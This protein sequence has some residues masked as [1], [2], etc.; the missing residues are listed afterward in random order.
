[1]NGRKIDPREL[2]AGINL[3]GYFR[4]ELGVGEAGR[5]LNR[6]REEA[7]SPTQ[8]S[9]IRRPLVARSTPSSKAARS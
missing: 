3:A 4:A 2:R 7:G 9:R 1:M 8:P 5:H 6:G